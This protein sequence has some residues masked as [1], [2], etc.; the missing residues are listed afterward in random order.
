[1]IQISHESS[2][3]KPT[4]LEQSLKA[5][6]IFGEAEF[7]GLLIGFILQTI[8]YMIVIKEGN[9]YLHIFRIK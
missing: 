9:C 4:S 7:K 2:Y 6:L 1:M 8:C 3:G 5:K